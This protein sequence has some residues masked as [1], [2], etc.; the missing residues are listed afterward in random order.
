MFGGWLKA[1]EFDGRF[2]IETRDARGW[3]FGNCAAR[4]FKDMNG[5]DEGWTLV[6]GFFAPQ[7]EAVTFVVVR[8]RTPLKGKISLKELFLF[9]VNEGMLLY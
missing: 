2:W 3:Q 4:Y 1:N 6:S 5:V 9:P 8:T 7:A